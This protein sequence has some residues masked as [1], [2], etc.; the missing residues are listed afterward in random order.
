MAEAAE[1]GAEVPPSLAVMPSYAVLIQSFE[2]LLGD[3]RADL[4]MQI[5]R[6]AP[7]LEAPCRPVAVTRSLRPRCRPMRAL[8]LGGGSRS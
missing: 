7:G 4:V 6:L 3:R 5:K 1:D 2:L 8:S